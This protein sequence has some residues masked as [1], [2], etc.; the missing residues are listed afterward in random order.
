MSGQKFGLAGSAALIIG[1]FCGM[2]DLVTLPIWVGALVERYAF[3]P[4]QAG[5]IVTLFLVGAVTAS[6]TVASRFNEMNQ[7]LWAFVGFAAASAAFWAA[8]METSFVM[9]ALLHFVA[10]LAIGVALSMVHGTIGRSSNPHRLYAIAG[11][12]LG[13]FAILLLGVI[14]QLLIKFGG[15]VIFQV[16]GLIMTIAAVSCGLMFRNPDPSSEPEKTPFSRATWLTIFG[17]GIMTFNQAMVFSFVE[18]IGKDRGFSPENVLAVLIA[19]GFVNFIFPSPLAAVLQTRV[20][21][22]VVTQVGPLIQIVLAL[23]VTSAT[24]FPLWA[25]AA[26]VFV[27][28]QIFTH[29][30]VFGHLAKLDPTGRAVAAT[31]AMLMVGA[32]LGPI[33]GGALGQNFGYAALGIAA[34]V[35]GFTSIGFFTKAKAA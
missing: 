7:R 18:V 26:A 5:A 15:A 35:F 27:S 4:Q 25:A 10:G 21:A 29:N 32:A 8:S 6:I 22:T 19:L 30:F 1:N 20:R 31:P 14:P 23:I 11:V 3:S 17:I 28:V 33:V 2:L 24:I 34:I 16:F 12:A 13:L 9:L